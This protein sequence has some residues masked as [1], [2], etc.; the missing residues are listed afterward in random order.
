MVQI[1]APQF[2]ISGF[3]SGPWVRKRPFISQLREP[4]PRF[5]N[6]GTGG[7]FSSG[8]PHNFSHFFKSLRLLKEV[9]NPDVMLLM[10]PWKLPVI[11]DDT[12]CQNQ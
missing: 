7:P 11:S 5:G 3:R 1:V 4:I 8:A 12:R 10:A 9:Q 6:T 2:P